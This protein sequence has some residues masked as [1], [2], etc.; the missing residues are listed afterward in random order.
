MQSNRR[1]V[2]MGLLL[3]AGATVASMS[4]VRHK[5]LWLKESPDF[6][7]LDTQKEMLGALAELVIPATDTPGARSADI[8]D[9]MIVLIRDCTPRPS[10]N[11]LIDG[12]RR[13]DLFCVK[14]YGCRF[15]T[16]TPAQ[17]DLALRDLEPS[18]VE[19]KFDKRLSAAIGQSFFDTLKHVVTISYCTSRTGASEALAY[20]PIPGR[21][22]GCVAMKH[23][24]RAWAT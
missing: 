10:Q 12:L 18:S 6:E 8:V 21:F 7:Y 17:Q 22:L 1:K 24:Q 19:A 15:H 5:W 14:S 20:D 2:I 13:I 9:T 16:C 11:R 4:F 3:T 23:G